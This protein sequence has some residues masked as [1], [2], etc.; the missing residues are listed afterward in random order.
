MTIWEKGTYE[1][2]KCD[3]KKVEVTF[4]GERLRGR[5]GLFPIG[6][7]PK[8]WMIHRMDP[9]EDASAEP[10][11]ELGA[12]M[13]A[14][15]GKLP[16]AAD[17]RWA[18]EI[19]WDGVRAIAHSEPGRLRFYSRNLNEITPRYPELS[20]LN[21]ALSSH[22]AILDGEIIAFDENGKPSF[23][24]LQGRMHLTSESQVR[25][26][27]KSNPVSYVIFDLLWLDGHSLMREPYEARR[28]RLSELALNGERWQTP[29]YVA[30]HGAEVQEAARAQGLEG[31]VAKRLDCPYEP[32]R[33]SRGW[34]KVK[35]VTREDVVIGGW[36]PGEGR[37]LER[38]GALI[39]GLPDGEGGLQYSGRGGTGFP[40]AE[41]DPRAGL[42]GPLRPDRS[43]FSTAGMPRGA[44]F[45]EPRLMCT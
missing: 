10:M 11:P 19:K 28:A 17:D 33:R 14:T 2:A 22:R 25:R 9:P 38:I 6:K 27:A 13:L 32:G 7:E 21:R 29:D 15:A 37:R 20:K 26:L 44:V 23:S 36:M 35:N 45:V 42:L 3:D 5:Y 39:V 34:T 4:H 12:P 8:D 43:P 30:G 1:L 24:A 41:L 31:I 16:P 40:E 18:F